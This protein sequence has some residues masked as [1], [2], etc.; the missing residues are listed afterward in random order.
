[1]PTR[2]PRKPTKNKKIVIFYCRFKK[3]YYFCSNLGNN[4]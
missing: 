1:M 4:C 3:M 2:A